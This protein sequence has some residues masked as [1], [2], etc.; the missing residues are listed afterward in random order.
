MLEPI[1]ITA[2]RPLASASRLKVETIEHVL[3]SNGHR[4]HNQPTVP[5]RL[6]PAQSSGTLSLSLTLIPLLFCPALLLSKKQAQI[7]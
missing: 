5:G 7:I 2:R 4:P 1:R 3:P 6:S